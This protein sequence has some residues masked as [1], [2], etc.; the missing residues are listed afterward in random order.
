LFPIAACSRKTSLIR[1]ISDLGLGIVCN[2]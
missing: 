2:P 1:R